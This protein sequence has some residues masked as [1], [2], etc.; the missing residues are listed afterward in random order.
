MNSTTWDTVKYIKKVHFG[1]I[2]GNNRTQTKSLHFCGSWWYKLDLHKTSGRSTVWAGIQKQRSKAISGLT[3]A[4]W[5]YFS[6]QAGPDFKGTWNFQVQAIIEN[7]TLQ[8]TH[9]AQSRGGV[10][11]GWSREAEPGPETRYPLLWLLHT[12]PPHPGTPQ[13]HL[14]SHCRNSGRKATAPQ[15]LGCRRSWKTL[16]QRF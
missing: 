11:P 12:P 13:N 14:A 5:M 8:M 16:S 15:Q 4:R 1:E 9:W 2:M 3:R 6:G 10:G 7:C